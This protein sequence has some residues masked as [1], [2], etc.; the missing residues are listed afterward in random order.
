MLL[1]DP[2]ANPTCDPSDEDAA[3]PFLYGRVIGVYHVNIV[4]IGPGMKDY[5]AMRFDF[6][7]VRWFQFDPIQSR[8]HRKSAWKSLRLDRLS[9]PPMAERTS[10]GFVDPDLVLR[11][12]HLIPA[13]SFGKARDD[14]ISI[15]RMLRDSRDWKYYYVNRPAVSPSL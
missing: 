4:Y 7:H 14:G 12:C 2:K 9:F 13:Y 1:A 3:H 6:L 10:L 8:G 11:S 15:S 5:D